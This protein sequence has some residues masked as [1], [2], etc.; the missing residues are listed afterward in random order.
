VFPR[1]FENNSV[2]ELLCLLFIRNTDNE[3]LG[4]P[5]ILGF[6]VYQ[7]GRRRW[8][9]T[10]G[11]DRDINHHRHCIIHLCGLEESESDSAH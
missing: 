3:P 10:A 6:Q 4:G 11:V 8:S 5:G 1:F 7:H 2:R 9:I